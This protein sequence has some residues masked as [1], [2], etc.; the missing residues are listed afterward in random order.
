MPV[1]TITQ[2]TVPAGLAVTNNV[3]AQ[4][5][6]NGDTVVTSPSGPYGLLV[7][8]AVAAE[9]AGRLNYNDLLPSPT[10]RDSV[11]RVVR[12]LMPPG[13][14][15][16][17]H[18]PGYQGIGVV[19]S[20]IPTRALLPS[21]RAVLKQGAEEALYAYFNPVSGG[22]DHTGWPFGRPVHL[23][24]AYGVLDRLPG[25]GRVRTVLL[26]PMS[27]LTGERG[28]ETERV[29]VTDLSTVFS[30]DHQVTVED[31]GQGQVR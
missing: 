25:V 14:T 30:V 11:E 5:G 20:V 23:G 26:Y 10:L 15:V 24:D 12:P 4:D 1:G 6:V 16:G 3:P 28:L 17:V 2:V 31:L 7:I 21:D 29:D 27:V 8:P 13:T 9:A 19:A 22:P 18:A